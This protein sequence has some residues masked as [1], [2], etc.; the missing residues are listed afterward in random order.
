M[1][2]T[3]P[4]SR[5]PDTVSAAARPRAIRARTTRRT[6]SGCASR[7]RAHWARANAPLCRQTSAIHTA[8]S[9]VQP[10][11]VSA[12]SRPL[13]WAVEPLA[14]E[15]NFR[16][17][18]SMPERWTTF[19]RQVNLLEIPYSPATFEDVQGGRHA[20]GRRRQTACRTL[21]SV[22][23]GA[24]STRAVDRWGTDCVGTAH[25]GVHDSKLLCTGRVRRGPP[26]PSGR[27]TTR[28]A[29]LR[30]ESIGWQEDGAILIDGF[31]TRRQ[32]P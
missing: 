24:S 7:N 20:V 13:R 1:R 16:F 12:Q 23:R 9:P 31:L 6:C 18:V 21:P 19:R 8:F 5:M 4:I 3:R 10:S 25:A 11:C 29:A 15:L 27:G 28:D 26:K 14:R 22:L 30:T 32:R 17:S 2:Q